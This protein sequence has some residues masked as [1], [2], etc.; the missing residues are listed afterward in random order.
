[1]KNIKILSDSS[2]S[3]DKNDPL[4]NQVTLIPLSIIHNNKQYLD[5]IDLSSDDVN[6]L[7]NDNQMIQTSQPSIGKAIEVL[8]SI[9]PENYDHIYIITVSS[10]LSGTINSITQ[11]VDHL[12]LS[13]VTI[14]DTMSVAGPAYFVA[15][16]IYEMSNEGKSNVEII[17]AINKSLDDTTSFVYPETLEQLKR[18]GR[19]SKGAATLASLLKIKPIL[20][21]E[22]KGVT[23]EKF[24]TART[25]SKVYEKMVEEMVKN[26][27]KPETH[28]LYYL[29][30]LAKDKVE[31]LD[32]LIADTIGKFESKTLTLPAVL[33]THIGIGGIALQWIRKVKWFSMPSIV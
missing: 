3:I 26:N 18:G 30:N 28:E 31:V 7:I 19:I 33:V 25:E 23:I 2:I 27:I 12:G 29:E 13:N 8:E 4:Y 9:K 10:K 21:L 16:T 5:Q 14:I 15:K 32:G 11:A 20:V 6:N 1:M 22:N 24:A 17:Q